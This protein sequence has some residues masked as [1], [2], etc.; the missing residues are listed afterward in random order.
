MCKEKLPQRPSAEDIKTMQTRTYEKSNCNKI[1]KAT[2][3]ILQNDYYFIEKVD[4]QIGFVL[5]SRDVDTRDKYVDIKKEYGC[6]TKFLGVKRFFP[7]SPSYAKTE[8]S[9]NITAEG[10]NVTVRIS[11]RK[12]VFNLYDSAIKAQDITDK[13]KYEKFYSDL[14][15][16]L[17]IK[18]S[19]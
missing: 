9:T 18:K 13:E 4:S 5:A 14:N 2:L 17:K 11:L 6:S 12:K 19:K 3:N 8:V 1:M 16:E 7:F 10:E 15:E